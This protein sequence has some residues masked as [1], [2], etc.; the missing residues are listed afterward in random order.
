MNTCRRPALPALPRALAYLAE[1]MRVTPDEAEILARSVSQKLTH[2]F[3]PIASCVLL[4]A[5]AL[6]CGG[7]AATDDG[8]ATDD[9]HVASYSC[10]PWF[11][12]GQSYGSGFTLK[13]ASKSATIT[14]HARSEAHPAYAGAIDPT[15][16]PTE[17]K[18][19]G[20]TRYPFKPNQKD[21]PEVDTF[22]L[23]VQ[24]NV[25]PSDKVYL[26]FQGAEG[27]NT[28]TYTCGAP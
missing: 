10:T 18:Y 14:D 22:A 24:P 25:K 3:W 23:L 21:F 9:I 20:Y 16:K 8:S 6:G 27:G 1:A 15:Y 17:A 19:A 11:F 7:A 4:L 2:P 12:Y 5:L 13:L 26:R 28:E